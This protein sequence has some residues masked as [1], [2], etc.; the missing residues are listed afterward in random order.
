MDGRRRAA[1]RF[2]RHSV[3]TQQS[4][5]KAPEFLSPSLNVDIQSLCGIVHEQLKSIRS[6]MREL[7]LSPH[8]AL[9]A[10]PSP[11]HARIGRFIDCYRLQ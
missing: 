5:V 11:R 6:S 8:T 10:P 1:D 2:P 4:S 3:N 9:H 7:Q